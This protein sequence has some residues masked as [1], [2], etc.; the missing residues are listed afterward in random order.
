MINAMPNLNESMEEIKKD[1]ENLMKD[2]SQQKNMVSELKMDLDH[3]RI[4]LE[5]GN[6][7][8]CLLKSQ[9]VNR[10]TELQQLRQELE[11][12]N[13]KNSELMQQLETAKSTSENWRAKSN[14]ETTEL[15][16]ELL[17][18]K[19]QLKKANEEKHEL[20][21]ELDD[22]DDELYQKDKEMLRIDILIGKIAAEVETWTAGVEKEQDDI[23][24][25]VE[26]R[27]RLKV[28]LRTVSD[29]FDNS[30]EKCI[31]LDLK[32]KIQMEKYTT[33]IDKLKD[34]FGL[35]LKRQEDKCKVHMAEIE[36]LKQ[37]S[38][39]SQNLKAELEEAKKVNQ[40]L[41]CMNGKFLRGLENA[42]KRLSIEIYGSTN[43]GQE[44]SKDESENDN[45]DPPATKKKKS[46][47]SK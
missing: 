44:S 20:N 36:Q 16:T 38:V 26:E 12:A 18:C 43:D 15:E 17:K 19:D 22:L 21:M 31:K 45:F 23:K 41:R 7:K 42:G 24:C 14:I 35:E 10:E 13:D 46:N 27:D 32:L 4:E 9:L 25:I 6:S 5:V 8:M 30:I 29:N 33:E 34:D 3:C 11:L 40:Q 39:Q 37:E 47:G 28:E 2:C 1:Y